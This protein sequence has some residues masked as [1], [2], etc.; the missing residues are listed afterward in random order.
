MQRREFWHKFTN[1]W[2][3]PAVSIC[4]VQDGI[5]RL[6]LDCMAKDPRRRSDLQ[7]VLPNCARYTH[8]TVV[9][10]K[11]NPKAATYSL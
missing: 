7:A 3:E 1:V 8:R 10:F 2:D 5:S 11:Y 9:E 6:P 4:R